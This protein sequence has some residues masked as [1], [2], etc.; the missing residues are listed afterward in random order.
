MKLGWHSVVE[1]CLHSVNPLYFCFFYGIDIY[2]ISILFCFGFSCNGDGFVFLS[3]G[4]YFQ[5]DGWHCR[6]T[7]C[8]NL[9]PQLLHCRESLSSH[10]Q[11]QIRFI[12]RQRQRQ[13][14]YN[15]AVRHFALQSTLL[16]LL[17]AKQTSLQEK[18]K[19][20]WETETKTNSI[21]VR[22]LA[23]SFIL[24]FCTTKRLY[25]LLQNVFL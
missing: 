16:F 7:F 13:M 25:L 9:H 20:D 10:L 19:K 8:T 12:Q 2:C 22:H 23:P 17:I 24:A 11:R 1:V 6:L 4:S 18:T 14:T 5:T 15:I 3:N 21:A